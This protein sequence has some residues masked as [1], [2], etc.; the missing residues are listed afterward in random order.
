MK[1]L[2]NSL[3]QKDQHRLFF[4]ALI[5]DFFLPEFSVST[6][7]RLLYLSSS[8]L[9][10]I[11]PNFHNVYLTHWD[12]AITFSSQSATEATLSSTVLLVPLQNTLWRCLCIGFTVFIWLA[13]FFQLIF[14]YHFQTLFYVLFI[15]M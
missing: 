15:T 7:I 11:I 12:C 13:R 1:C 4:A 6:I 3:H 8:V 10:Y 9:R 5:S 14:L 2:L